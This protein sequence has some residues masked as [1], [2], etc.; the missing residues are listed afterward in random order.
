MYCST[1]VEVVDALVGQ[2]TWYIDMCDVADM[3]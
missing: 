2:L 3:L 1:F